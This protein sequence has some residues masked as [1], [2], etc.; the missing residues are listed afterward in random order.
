MQKPQMIDEDQFGAAL[1]GLCV[2]NAM[3]FM[4]LASPE[5]S[6]AALE[7][8]DRAADQMKTGDGLNQIR[9]HVAQQTGLAIRDLQAMNAAKR[10][11]A[12]QG[13]N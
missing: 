12:A 3:M 10:H 4:L 13:R 5:Q 1:D 11:P 9:A 7:L 6:D 8:L 2:T